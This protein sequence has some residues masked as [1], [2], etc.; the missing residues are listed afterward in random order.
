V[1]EIA[2]AAESAGADAIS[3]INTVAGMRIDVKR[4][5]P[6]LANGMGGLSGPAI[7]PVAVRM[8]WEV[9]RA[10]KIPV[11]GMGGIMSGE[12]A[13]E[14]FMAGASAVAVG[15]AALVNPVAP[16]EILEGLERFMAENGFGD[17]EELKAAC[18]QA[19]RRRG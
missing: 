16:V 3:L 4:R 15:T 1:A 2:R 9:S 19:A 13:A 7:K 17:I 11:I 5:A 10:V 18:G 14:F 8:V 12:D 6:V